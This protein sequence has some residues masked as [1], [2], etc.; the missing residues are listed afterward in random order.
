[1]TRVRKAKPTSFTAAVMLGVLFFLPGVVAPQQNAQT[2]AAAAAPVAARVSLTVDPAQS[3]VHWTVPSTLHTV[4]GTFG[5]TGGSMS[6]DPESG[7]ASGEIVVDTKSGE[8]G[9]GGRDKR[10]HNEILET[11]KFP[12]AVFRPTRVE[13]KVSSSGG[14]DVK[15]YGTLSVHG[16]DHQITALVHAEL[17]GK[18]WKGSAKF[19]V[20]YVLWGIKDPSNFML[21]VNH[22]VSVEIEMSGSLEPA[23]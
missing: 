16:G 4:H 19:D 21:K 8:S 11:A 7:S 15:V 13:G 17:A 2:T 5:V 6:F 22:V 10:M 20:P 9:N 18:S 14:C 23:N 1:M 12:E 3:R